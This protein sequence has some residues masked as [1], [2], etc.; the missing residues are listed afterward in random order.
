[1]NNKSARIQCANSEQA[2]SIPF[3]AQLDLRPGVGGSDN[4]PGTV[5]CRVAWKHKSELGLE[6]NSVLSVGIGELQRAFEKEMR[7]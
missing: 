4:I 1:M 3:D 5:P 7:T 2:D 6:F